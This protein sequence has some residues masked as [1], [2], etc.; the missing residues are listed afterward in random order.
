MIRSFRSKETARIWEASWARG[1]PRDIQQRAL[2]KLQMLN[3]ASGLRDLTI[4]SSNRLEPL[5]GDRRGQWSIRVNDR[6]R[7]CFRWAAPDAY[8][9]ELVDYHD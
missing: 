6:W 5:K 4:P 3:A 8:D 2:L 1:I 7:I 9:V